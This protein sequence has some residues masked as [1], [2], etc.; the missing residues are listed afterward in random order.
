[1]TISGENQQTAIVPQDASV[2]FQ[3]LSGAF[4]AIGDAGSQELVPQSLLLQAMALLGAVGG[5]IFDRRAGV[6]AKPVDGVVPE[7]LMADARAW[8]G[9]AGDP[10]SY[11]GPGEPWVALHFPLRQGEE[12]AIIMQFPVGQ[13]PSQ[14]RLSALSLMA[15]HAQARSMYLAAT[16]QMEV[17]KLEA[18]SAHEQQVEMALRLYDLYEEAQNQ[19]IT[20]GLTGLATHDFFQQRLAQ[21]VRESF[22][23]NRPLTFMIFDLDHFKNINDTYGHQAGDLVLKGAAALLQ[24]KVRA[25]DLVAR[26]GGE[27]F[28]VIL[29]H[30]TED[31]GY[32]L[33]ERLRKD[34]EAME[35]PVSSERNIRVT[36]SI[37]LASRGE[38]DGSSK[39]LIKRA[40]VALYA[41][42]NGGRNRVM[43]AAGPAVEAVSA[44]G[45][46]RQG[47]QEMFY[48]LARAFSAAIEARIPMMAGH[49]EATGEFARRMG[50]AMGLAEDKQEALYIAGLLHD[51]GMMG[52]PESVIFK[53]TSLDDTDWGKMKD[54]PA[55]GVGILARFSTFSGL[56]EAV[57]YHHERYD[58][59]GYPEGLKGNGIPMGARILAICDSYDAMIR[60][61]Y[62]YGVG[63]APGAARAEVE[64]CSGSQFDPELVKLFLGVLSETAPVEA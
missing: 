56:L 1:M 41:A 12:V 60:G 40:D 35:W 57:L 4:K 25:S 51:V 24:E 38:N 36:A 33:A 61:D 43:R 15:S 50:A 5:V 64:R 39:D 49:S 37:G 52:V 8:E 14:E 44:I 29:P 27:E 18:K 55:A 32:A 26:Y 9:L 34:L 13:V 21:E 11:D 58:G 62:A 47:S 31:D 59:K 20:D 45:S 3:A 48:G 42:K 23:Y 16:Q 10:R 54:H 30:T 63:I 17:A 53:P 2:A 7:R 28:A 22:R 19:A 46:V 6:R